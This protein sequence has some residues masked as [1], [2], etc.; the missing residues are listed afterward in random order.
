MNL[1]SQNLGVPGTTSSGGGDLFGALLGAAGTVAPMMCLPSG[2]L[3]ELANGDNA[4]VEDL[5]VGDDVV[6]GKII[7]TH[8]RKRSENHQFYRHIFNT[9]AVVMSDGHPYHD[10]LVGVNLVDHGS[11]NTYDILTDQGFYLVNGVKLGS[12][13]SRI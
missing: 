10:T 8:S 11:P 6:G 5:K 13:I 9:G 12:T 1:Y 3:I 7:A 2:T 4:R